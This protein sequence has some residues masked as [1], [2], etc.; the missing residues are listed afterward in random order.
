M[1]INGAMRGL[2]IKGRG[3]KVAHDGSGNKDLGGRNNELAMNGD[4]TFRTIQ[5]VMPGS[6]NDIQV[7]VDDSR[8]DHEYLQNL[9]TEGLPVPVVATYADNISYTGDMVI[10]GEIKP[11]KNT[12]LVGLSL[13]GTPL[14]QI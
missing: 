4:A 6:L 2:S 12:G 3:F 10:T 1:A 5:T 14:T 9:A 8:G 11:D 13:Q 7:E